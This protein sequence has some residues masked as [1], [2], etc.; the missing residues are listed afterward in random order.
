M[1][2]AVRDIPWLGTV[3]GVYYVHWYDKESSRTKRISLGTKDAGEAQTRYALFLSQGS[4]IYS[5]RTARLTVE[6]AL[7]DY[8]REH[9]AVE[10]AAAWRQEI[11]IRHL[12]SFFAGVDIPDVDI[13][14]SRAYAAHRGRENISN[15]TIRREL[16][17]LA[18]AANHAVK[19]KR[20]PAA[21]LPSIELPKTHKDPALADD[22]WYTHAELARLFQCEDD[23]LR[24]FIR[25]AYFTAARRR[26]VEWLT[27]GQIRR[28]GPRNTWRI[29]LAAPGEKRTKKRKAIVPLFREIESDIAALEAATETDLL[30]G[31]HSDFYH[32]YR[33][34]CEAIGLAHKRNPHMLRHSR[35]THLLHDGKSI[36]AVAQLLGD[37]VQTVERVYG[38]HS[39]EFLSETLDSKLSIV[40]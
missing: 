30:F 27:L 17:A 9:V 31:H 6:Q 24:H 32:R 15:G 25:I 34:H 38:H 8:Y 22:E 23:R 4:D 26:A 3:N 28:I 7:D 18:A 20:M 21:D 11:A 16:N 36:Y 19:W 35:A 2:R 10:T 40:R 39:V 37:T 5:G 29:N 33:D 1:P 12:K 14:L 13:T